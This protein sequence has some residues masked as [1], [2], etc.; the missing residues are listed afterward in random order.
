[1][2]YALLFLA[3]CGDSS[4]PCG[5]VDDACITLTVRGDVAKIDHLE[6]DVPYPDRHDTITT[7]LPDNTPVSLPVVPTITLYL[8]ATPTVGLVSAGKLG[9]NGLGCGP[10]EP[11]EAT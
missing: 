4:D 1:M 11:V 5:G 6:L 8:H 3:A 2:R 7:A 10:T 9:L